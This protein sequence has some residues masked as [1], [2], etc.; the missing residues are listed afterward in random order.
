M[1]AST[2]DWAK[3]G[4]LYLDDGLWQGR[5]LLPRGWRRYVTS[6]TPA[7]GDAR[8]GAGFWRLPAGS[9]LPGGT[10]FASGFQ[11]QYV[12]VIPSRE[13]VVVRLGASHGANGV[14]AM[15]GELLAALR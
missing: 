12:I 14:W 15:V 6:I 5:R 4:Q 10:F 7:S 1:L 13:L 11:G 3:F 2:H 8:Y 9:G